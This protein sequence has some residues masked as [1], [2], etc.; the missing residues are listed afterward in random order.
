MV[1]P[2]VLQANASAVLSVEALVAS[3]IPLAEVANRSLEDIDL[4]IPRG[5]ALAKIWTLVA[6]GWDAR[7]VARRAAM[8]MEAL[9]GG[10]GWRKVD[11]ESAA[12]GAGAALHCAGQ[13]PAHN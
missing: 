2:N 6:K 4:K 10:S 12:G 1:E 13:E 5:V 8:L 11:V 7:I 3:L 9:R